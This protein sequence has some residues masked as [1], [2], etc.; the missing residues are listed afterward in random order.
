M[1]GKLEKIIVEKGFGFI[2]GED[3]N[4]YFFHRS[5]FNGFFEELAQDYYNNQNVQL[6]FN[7]MKTDKGYRAE[8][9]TR[10]DNQAFNQIFD[11]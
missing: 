5:G 4:Q 6:T 10:E 7:P 11:K 8:D 3:G 2:Q 9:V 1:I